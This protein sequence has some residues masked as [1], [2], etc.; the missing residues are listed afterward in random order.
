MLRVL[1]KSQLL[2]R[3]H[4]PPHLTRHTHYQTPG[5]HRYAFW[6]NA[7]GGYDGTAS[8]YRT[9]ED[10]GSNSDKAFIFDT[11][12][13]QYRCVSDCNKVPDH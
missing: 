1:P 7:A 13:V 8:D 4:S 3:R 10:D 12:S 2:R 9:I 6:H 11:A 5:W